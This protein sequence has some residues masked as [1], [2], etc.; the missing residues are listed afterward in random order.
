[1]NKNIIAITNCELYLSKRFGL[2]KCLNSFSYFH[3]DI[4]IYNWG[5]KE[6]EEIKRKWVGFGLT[7][8]MPIIMSEVKK[9][10]NADLVIKLDADSI[11]LGRLSEIIDCDDGTE[12]FGVRNDG[13]HIGNR[14]ESM[15][16]PEPIKN[17]PNHLYVNC[18]LIATTSDLFLDE[19]FNI[20]K[21]LIDTYKDIRV[22]PMAEQGTY[23]CLFHSGKYKTKILD[24]L[25]GD[26][27]YG[28][29]AN[30]DAHPENIPLSVQKEYGNFT[31]WGSY[32]DIEYKDNKFWLYNKQV[33]ALHF[34]GGGTWKNSNK[35]D[36]DLFNPKIIPELRRITNEYN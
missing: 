17:L 32:Q 31:N 1:M 8:F 5:D 29:S 18:G 4:P 20:N 35:M 6:T 21:Y 3:P 19:W 10:Y 14:D 30:I 2:D 9:K 28:S 33:K 26:L 36:F 11:V 25:G 15:N 13:D 24:P 22:I 27:F 34:A 23:N 7:S 16:R 12:I